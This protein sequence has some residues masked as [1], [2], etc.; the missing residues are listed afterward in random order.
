MPAAHKRHPS[1]FRTLEVASRETPVHSP[2]IEE[3][4]CVVLAA[5]LRRPRIRS[6]LE[7]ADRQRLVLDLAHEADQACASLAMHFQRLRVDILHDLVQFRSGQFHS[8]PISR[9]IRILPMRIIGHDDNGLDPLPVHDGA[10]PRASGLLDAKETS[11]P[12]NRFRDI[13]IVA[14]DAAVICVCRSNSSG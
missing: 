12:V 2:M 1:P 9:A 10:D 11:M 7:I 5:N 13:K 4:F 3:M 8:F 6:A 14:I